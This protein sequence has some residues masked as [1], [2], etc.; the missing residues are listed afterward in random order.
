MF[1][2]VCILYHRGKLV[3]NIRITTIFLNFIHRG[4]APANLKEANFP[5]GEF[6]RSDTVPRPPTGRSFNCPNLLT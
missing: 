4:L 6:R 2:Q 5:N 1:K 3:M